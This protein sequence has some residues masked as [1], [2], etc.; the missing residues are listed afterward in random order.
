MK[1]KSAKFN[2][3]CND[4]L[5]YRPQISCGLLISFR[6]GSEE[7]T[8]LVSMRSDVV[9][10]GQFIF[11]GQCHLGSSWMWISALVV[12]VLPGN[13]LWF[14]PFCLTSV[15]VWGQQ[16]ASGVFYERDPVLTSP[17]VEVKLHKED[18]IVF[19]NDLHL[20][21]VGQETKGAQ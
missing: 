4:G 13:W 18:V 10:K 19:S 16:Y 15:W 7:T 11:K 3:N 12:S 14:W 9:N 8:K 20:E 6:F 21:E 5:P 1:M 17:P 2:I